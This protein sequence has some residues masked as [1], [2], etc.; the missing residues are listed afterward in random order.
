[1]R[2]ET[3]N[4][5]PKTIIPVMKINN[6]PNFDPKSNSSKLI[7]HFCSSWH[8]AFSL[9]FVGNFSKY[10]TAHSHILWIMISEPNHRRWGIVEKWFVYFCHFLNVISTIVSNSYTVKIVKIAQICHSLFGTHYNF[11]RNRGQ[12][13]N[14][15][16]KYFVFLYQPS[17]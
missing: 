5:W 8:T 17:I 11:A 9:V 3:S 4:Y 6:G 14:N 2:S 16:Q 1:M 15:A 10:T 12:L 13:L 7:D